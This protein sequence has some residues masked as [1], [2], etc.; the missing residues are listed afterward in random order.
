MASRRRTTQRESQ[1]EGR[2]IW[3]MATIIAVIVMVAL[4]GYFTG[5]WE[6]PTATN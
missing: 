3:I 4:Y 2:F 1:H 5:A 6:A